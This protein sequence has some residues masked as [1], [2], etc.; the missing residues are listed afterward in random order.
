MVHRTQVAITSEE[1]HRE[2]IQ[3]ELAAFEERENEFMKRERKERAKQLGLPLYVATVLL[4]FG[5][6]AAGMAGDDWPG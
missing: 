4:V 1:R 5:C 2:V 3:Q 6:V